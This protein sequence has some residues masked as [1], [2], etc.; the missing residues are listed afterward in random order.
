MVVKELHI[1]INTAMSICIKNGY[2]IFPFAVGKS[3]KIKVVKP[4]GSEVVYDKLVGSKEVAAAYRKTYIAW[5]KEINK[6]QEDA[7]KT[8]T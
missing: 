3:F 1:D 7:S 8:N 6:T 5:A 2:Q 4:D